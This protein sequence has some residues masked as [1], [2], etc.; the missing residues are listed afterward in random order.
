MHI[1]N[2]MPGLCELSVYVSKWPKDLDFAEKYN[3]KCMDNTL[4]IGPDK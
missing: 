1:L 3:V 2:L 4:F